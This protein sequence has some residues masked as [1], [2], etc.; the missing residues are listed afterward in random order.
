[1][2]LS[3]MENTTFA[4]PSIIDSHDIGL[5]TVLQSRCPKRNSYSKPNFAKEFRSSRILRHYWSPHTCV[6]SE[7]SLG[8]YLRK[9]L[10][11]VFPLFKPHRACVGCF[12]ETPRSKVMPSE[13]HQIAETGTA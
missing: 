10:A 12:G 13:E 9:G 3:R 4:M 11:S 8:R 7:I 5:R 2:Q 1:M 6:C